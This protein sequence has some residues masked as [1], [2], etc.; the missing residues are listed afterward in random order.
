MVVPLALVVSGRIAEAMRLAFDS[1]ARESLPRREKGNRGGMQR[2]TTVYELR[3]YHVVPGKMEELVARFRDYTDKLSPPL[4]DMDS[5][6]PMLGQVS[7]RVRKC[8]GKN[9]PRYSRKRSRFR[10]R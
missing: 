10:T 5:L 7:H 8:H 2:S 1:V 6:L 4:M 9:E 3:I